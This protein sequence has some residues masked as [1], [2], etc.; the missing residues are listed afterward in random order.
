MG[1]FSPLA[2]LLTLFIFLIST[3]NKSKEYIEE[4][5]QKETSFKKESKEFKLLLTFSKIT[6]LYDKLILFS[7]FNLL[8]TS[9]L[10]IISLTYENEIKCIP[11]IIRSIIIYIPSSVILYFSYLYFKY[12]SGIKNEDIS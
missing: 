2:L 5:L 9:L 8:F 7:T 12:L 11:S 10:I 4:I 1:I 3:G 6:F